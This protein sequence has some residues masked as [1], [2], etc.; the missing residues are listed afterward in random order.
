MPYDQPHQ[1]IEVDLSPE[2]ETDLEDR[3]E[4]LLMVEPDPPKNS[5]FGSISHFFSA[6]SSNV[7]NQHEVL[8]LS[9][10]DTSPDQ[11]FTLER[12]TE[13]AKFR[14]FSFL[15]SVFQ[16]NPQVVP[17]PDTELT[18][19]SLSYDDYLQLGWSPLPA[20]VMIGDM[21]LVQGCIDRGYSL[22][23]LAPETSARATP[24]LLAIE[25]GRSAIFDYLL[26]AGAD[27]HASDAYGWTALHHAVLRKQSDIVSLLIAHGVSLE[28]KTRESL[29]PL[30]VAAWESKSEQ[31]VKTLLDACLS[32]GI[33]VNMVDD[34]GN[35]ALMLALKDGDKRPLN[36][37]IITALMAFSRLDVANSDGETPEALIKLSCPHLLTSASQCSI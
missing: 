27:L 22:E 10:S 23:D 14:P 35:T 30:M 29:T 24:L 16:R 32:Q 7:D 31:I 12:A 17:L 1:I 18:T 11:R 34:N 8:D 36:I 33:D 37:D 21:G 6:S 9:S 26:N 20:A 5:F 3:S 19:F 2:L 4:Q 13:P 25:S 15:S 28:S